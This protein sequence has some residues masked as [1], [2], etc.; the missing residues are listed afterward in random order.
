MRAARLVA[1][2]IVGLAA[3]ASV[4]CN[5]FHYYDITVSFNNNPQASGFGANEVQ[6]VILLIFSVSGADS[7]SFPIGPN[8]KGVPVPNGG[9]TLGVVEY[10][11]FADSGTLNF[12]V[13]AWDSNGIANPNC[14]VGEGTK[15]V[16]AT[17]A[18]TTSDSLSIN[19]TGMFGIDPNCSN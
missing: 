8:S 5:D 15:A 2:W 17:S 7:G 18:S 14:K 16:M 11:T 6:N 1:K 3:L 9:T 19:K 4:G 12:Q 13:T 10:S